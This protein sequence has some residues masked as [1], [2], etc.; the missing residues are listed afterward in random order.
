MDDQ[1]EKEEAERKA[2]EEAKAK[3]EAAAAADSDV[4]KNAREKRI[5]ETL[6]KTREAT[7]ELRK[8]NIE[9]R[10]IHNAEKELHEKKQTALELAGKGE[11]GQSQGSELTDEEKASRKRIKAIADVSGSSWGKK[12]E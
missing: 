12:Y 9:R 6:E 7:D 4:R 2:A 1:K 10:E 5:D 11:A 8:Q 3:E